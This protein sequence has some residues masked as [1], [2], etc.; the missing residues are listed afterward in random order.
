MADAALPNMLKGYFLIS[1][2]DVWVSDFTYIP[3]D[4]RFIYVATSWTEWY[5][6]ILYSRSYGRSR[7]GTRDSS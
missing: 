2:G 3:Y 4:G 5:Y 6:A 7:T 1:V